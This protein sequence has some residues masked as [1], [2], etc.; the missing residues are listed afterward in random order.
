M[1][2]MIKFEVASL[3]RGSHEVQLAFT[4][5]LETIFYPLFL[6]SG[7]STGYPDNPTASLTLY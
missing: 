1:G 5:F 7:L 4:Y 3:I 2:R 6:E